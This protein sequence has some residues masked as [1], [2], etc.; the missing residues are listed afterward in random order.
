[1]KQII[2]M[3]I[4]EVFL[5]EITCKGE[6]AMEMTEAE[7]VKKYQKNPQAKTIN[8]LADLNGCQAY[9]IKRILGKAGVYV[10]KAGRLKKDKADETIEKIDEIEQSQIS[11]RSDESLND[12][13]LK[14]IQKDEPLQE[15]I[16]LQST[17]I[18]PIKEY[19]IPDVVRQVIE[20]EIENIGIRIMNIC[21]EADRLSAR[22]EEL[23]A[24]LKGE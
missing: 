24:F 8:I 22:R 19:M 13:I 21:D 9:E 4:L 1:M 15:E 2:L 5:E 10:P 14:A 17:V 6:R 23:K 3:K 16:R 20:V 18:E 7:I 11:K 12:N